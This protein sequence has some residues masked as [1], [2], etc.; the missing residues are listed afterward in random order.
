MTRRA[1]RPAVAPGPEEASLS[2][3]T[4]LAIAGAVVGFILLFVLPWYVGAA[5]IVL[6]LGLPA[7]AY[8]MLDPS[9]RRRLREIQ[10]RKQLGR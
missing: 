7:A 1:A 3:R 5:V 8:L 2:G 6:A 9:Q 4:K 10:R